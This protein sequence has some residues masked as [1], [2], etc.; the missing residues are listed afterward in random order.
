MVCGRVDDGCAPVDAT[1]VDIPATGDWPRAGGIA[2]R[3]PSDCSSG[4]G[5]RSIDFWRIA[6]LAGRGVEGLNKAA[7]VELVDG[8]CIE[9][10]TNKLCDVADSVAPSKGS[11]CP[12]AV[13]KC[14][15]FRVSDSS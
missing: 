6:W 15:A 7:P 2:F 10:A 13:Y 4:L 11:W 1:G 3:G 12:Q 5:T 8:S 9:G 14:K